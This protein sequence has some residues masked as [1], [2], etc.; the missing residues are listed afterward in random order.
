MLVLYKDAVW[1]GS[2]AQSVHHVRTGTA[3]CWD[4]PVQTTCV[5]FFLCVRV[6][7]FFSFSLFQMWSYEDYVSLLALYIFNDLLF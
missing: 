4:D 6:L 5:L 3:L 1:K 7:G 2:S